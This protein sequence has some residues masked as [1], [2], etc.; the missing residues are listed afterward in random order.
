MARVVEISA[1]VIAIFILSIMTMKSLNF[2]RASL[3]SVDATLQMD[4]WQKQDKPPSLQQWQEAH[5]RLQQAIELEQENPL[6]STK[7]AELLQ[8]QTSLTK[9]T[10]TERYQ[11]SLPHLRRTI[12]LRPAWAYGWAKLALAKHRAAELDSEMRKAI[13]NAFIA[14]PNDKPIRRTVRIIQNK[15]GSKI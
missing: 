10:K 9:T 12:N 7:I 1:A 14:A 4:S 2:A 6:H 13:I 11:R 5:Q 3:Y 15:N 8:I